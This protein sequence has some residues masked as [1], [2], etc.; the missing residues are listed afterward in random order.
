MHFEENIPKGMCGALEWSP[1]G[2]GGKGHGVQKIRQDKAFPPLIP[3]SLWEPSRIFGSHRAEAEL[4][5][6]EVG[7]I[8]DLRDEIPSELEFPPASPSV[9]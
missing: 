4:P 6:R 7:V 1:G 8:P 9:A 5:Q 3:A 2:I